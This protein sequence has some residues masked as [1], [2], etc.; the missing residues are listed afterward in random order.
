MPDYCTIIK[1]GADM[2]PDDCIIIK[3]EVDRDARLLYY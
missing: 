3:T 2:V 1:T